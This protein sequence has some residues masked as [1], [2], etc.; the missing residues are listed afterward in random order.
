[1]C[2]YLVVDEFLQQ[3]PEV[4]IPPGLIPDL[5]RRSERSPDED[6]VHFKYILYNDAV[7]LINRQIPLKN[8]A[9]EARFLVMWQYHDGQPTPDTK[10][11]TP[12]G[13]IVDAIIKRC[14]SL[15]QENYTIFH[16]LKSPN[17]F[18]RGLQRPIL[19]SLKQLGPPFVTWIKSSAADVDTLHDFVLLVAKNYVE[20][21]EKAKFYGLPE[22]RWR[23]EGERLMKLHFGEPN[24]ENFVYKELPRKGYLSSFILDFVRNRYGSRFWPDILPCPV[25]NCKREWNSGGWRVAAKVN[26]GIWAMHIFEEHPEAFDGDWG[27]KTQK[28][29][30]DI[31][32]PELLGGGHVYEPF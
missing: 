19:Q 14:V 3:W 24:A 21:M 4:K 1:M 27:F 12:M 16:K 7:D 26:V 23:D 22:L 29:R 10:T 28:W 18:Q 15:Y 25:K 32:S 6:P 5:S 8:Q 20:Q 31:R 9:K 30:I 13:Q 2:E 17:S 11:P